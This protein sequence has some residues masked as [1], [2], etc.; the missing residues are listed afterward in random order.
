MKR[1]KEM[2]RDM[3]MDVKINRR[4]KVDLS[5]DWSSRRKRRNKALSLTPVNILQADVQD[6]ARPKTV[7]FAHENKKTSN[8]FTSTQPQE[9][10]LPCGSDEAAWKRNHSKLNTD[11]HTH[12]FFCFNVNSE[13]IFQG[14]KKNLLPS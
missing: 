1:D 12:H 9:S 2:K 14:K 3:E 6:L 5:P 8:S 11:A 7:K 13:N 4:R 10:P